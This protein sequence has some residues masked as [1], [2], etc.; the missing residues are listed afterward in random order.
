MKINAAFFFDWVAVEPSHEDGMVE[1]VA[2]VVETGFG[3]VV[4]RREAVAEDI[5]HGARLRERSTESIVGVL[6]YCVT[7]GMRII[8]LRKASNRC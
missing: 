2:V 7:V 1:A 4:L 5:A 8:P 3:I 6:R